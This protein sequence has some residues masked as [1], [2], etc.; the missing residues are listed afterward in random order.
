MKTKLYLS[1]LAL[2]LLPMLVQ[3]NHINSGYISYTIDPDGPR[4]FNFTLTLLTNH[5]SQAE[6]PMVTMYMGDG[7]TVNVPRTSVKKYNHN[8]DIE[9]FEW[10][11]TYTT[12]RLYTVGWV[13]ENRNSNVLNIP[14]PSDQASFYVSTTVSV[15]PL[16]PNLH[17]IHLAGVPFLHGRVGEP[18]KYNLAA[19]DADGDNLTYKLVAPKKQDKEGNIV[20]IEGY[21]M[22]DGMTINEYG[23]IHWDAP[24]VAGKYTVAVQITEYKNGVEQGINHVDLEMII[25]NPE[26]DL[27]PTL[28]LLNKSQLLQ[29]DDGSVQVMPG[30]PLKLEYFMR[31]HPDTDEPVRAK[32]YSELDTLELLPIN[33]AVRD[34]ADGQAITVMFT[35][36]QELVREQAY[37]LA[38][39]AM[40]IYD[41][42]SIP[43]YQEKLI[44]SW[45]FTY[46]HI[47]NVTPTATDDD[48]K[49]AGFILYPNPV[50]DKFV[51]EAPDMPGMFVLLFDATGKRA[52]TLK[53]QPGKNNF[54]KPSSLANGLYFYTIYSRQQ[55]VGSGKLVVR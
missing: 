32:L 16:S 4:R 29:N 46:I 41:K 44:A 52:G 45:D 9:T 25:L 14:A 2:L 6:D 5:H 30:E 38:M 27:R 50:A 13:G 53:L 12:P 55:P 28:S 21:E 24:T 1:V 3:A 7:N 31:R 39:S 35:P 22:P 23:E 17:G 54:T 11:Y 10:S 8:Y 19:Y 33:I 18:F 43:T 20:A 49:N 36:G 42:Y 48:L 40:A 26:E 51:I 37:T 15:N 47:G 34:S